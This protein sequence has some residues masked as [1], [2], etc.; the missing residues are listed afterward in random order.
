M[1]R[2]ATFGSRLRFLP[3]L[4]LLATS[5]FLAFLVAQPPHLVHH[6]FEH[7]QK[8]TDCAFASAGKHTEGLSPDILTPIPVLT[9]GDGVSIAHQSP[10]PSLAL[11]PSHARAPPF[12][13]S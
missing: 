8:Q 5:C 6:L 11:T 3:L 10:L 12:L 2:A 4:G 9:E 1:I 7:G 13:D